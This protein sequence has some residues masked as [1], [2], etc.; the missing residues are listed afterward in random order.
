MQAFELECLVR[1]A[2]TL[3]IPEI[4]AAVSGMLDPD[5]LLRIRREAQRNHSGHW[6]EH[7]PMSFG[8]SII[9]DHVR[10]WSEWDFPEHTGFCCIYRF[11]V[12]VGCDFYSNPSG[13]S[14][15]CIEHHTPEEAWIRGLF[16]LGVMLQYS[17]DGNNT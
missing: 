9:T 14:F 6:D 2:Q 3:P 5:I 15:S 13:T 11:F 4:E 8:F 1:Q 17:D 10:V 7:N 16:L 12:G